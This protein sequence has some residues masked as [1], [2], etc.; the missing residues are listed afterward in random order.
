M[1]RRFMSFTYFVLSQTASIFYHVVFCLSRTFLTFSS[2]FFLNFFCLRS[3]SDILSLLFSDVKDFFQLFSK[4][5]SVLTGFPD[6]TLT[7]YHCF[8]CLSTV[9]SFFLVFSFFSF[10]CHT[11]ITVQ[12]TT[13]P[14]HTVSGKFRRLLCGL[15]SCLL[16]F[17]VGFT[18]SFSDFPPAF[19]RF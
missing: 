7:S 18:D 2:L 13:I 5:F 17:L 3:N 16:V 10:F 4:L 1:N 14:C 11:W 15:L 12:T 19:F 9:F 8:L 6:A